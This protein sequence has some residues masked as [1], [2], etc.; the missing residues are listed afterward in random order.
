ML[1]S[2]VACATKATAPGKGARPG[3]ESCRS[4]H[5]SG[6]RCGRARPQGGRRSASTPSA[7]A[8]S[9]QVGCMGTLR[10]RAAHSDRCAASSVADCGA[11]A[12]TSSSGAESSK[13]VS[14]AAVPEP[15]PEPPTCA[16]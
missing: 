13:G 15:P 7:T 12:V 2:T 5:A 9:V 10:A 8:I 1:Q 4:T 16:P 3:R 14:A 6:P 11:G